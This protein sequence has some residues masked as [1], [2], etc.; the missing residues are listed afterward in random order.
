MNAMTEIHRDDLMKLARRID[1]V[2]DNVR[3]VHNEIGLP[4]SL[5]EALISLHRAEALLLETAQS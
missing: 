1:A 5:S 3:R 2:A 4:L